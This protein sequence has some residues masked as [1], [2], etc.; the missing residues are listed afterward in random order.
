MPKFRITE[1][2]TGGGVSVKTH[3][4]PSKPSLLFLTTFVNK[5]KLKILIDTGATT[6][7]IHEKILKHLLSLQYIE[8]SPYSFTLADGIAPFHVLGVVNLSVKFANSTTT[9]K[10][11]IANRLCTDMILGMDYINKYNLNI[12]I[13]HQTISIENN[14]KTYTMDIDQDYGIHK[15]PVTTYHSITIPPHSKRLTHVSVP[16]SSICSSFV[17]TSYLH[18]KTSLHTTYTFLQFQN[19]SSS[20]RFF[21]NSSIPRLLHKGSC[22]GFLLCSS[23]SYPLPLL[24]LSKLDYFEVTR[25]PGSTSD[26]TDLSL[27]IPIDDK[28]FGVTGYTGITPALPEILIERSRDNDV[29]TSENSLRNSDTKVQEQIIFPFCNT[30]QSIKPAVEE[31]LRNLSNRIDDKQHQAEVFSLLKRYAPTFD[32]TTHNIAHTPINH[33]INTVPHS[34]PACKPYPQPNTEEPM[35]KLIQEFLDASPPN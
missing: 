1:S 23:E 20:L 11:H 18:L 35:Y 15:I 31:H 24:S 4:N 29:A 3:K 10:A 28:S 19:Y 21:N 5:H 16:I 12:N 17:S 6:T 27:T 13:I 32:I 25:S 7:F 9:I 34:P 33:V 26:S 22:I 2:P 14:N 30:I 8:K